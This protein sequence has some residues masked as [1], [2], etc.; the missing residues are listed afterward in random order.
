[1][2]SRRRAREAALQALYELD[3]NPGLL[4]EQALAHVFEAFG[5]AFAEPRGE[6]GWERPPTDAAARLELAERAETRT[7]AARLVHG[8]AGARAEIDRH[9]GGASHNWRLDR[10]A[11]VDRN[12]LRMAAYELLFEPEIP[13]SVTIDEAVEIAK[14]FG[15]GDSPAFIN[16]VLHRIAA[17][18]KPVG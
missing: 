17:E 10:M 2:G 6:G 9:L 11:A 13:A 7:F 12:L 4:P 5:E 14:R 8:T 1:M 15:T 3:L 16:G 18:R